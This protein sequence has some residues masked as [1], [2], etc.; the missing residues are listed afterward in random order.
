MDE[1]IIAGIG[2]GSVFSPNHIGNDAAIFSLTAGE[3][4]AMG[5]VV[6]EYP[7]AALAEGGI[8][9]RFIFTMARDKHSVQT[10]LRYENEG[11]TV[12][13]SAYGIRNCTRET[14]TRLLLSHVI[15]HPRSLIV[16]TLTDPLPA[17]RR[18]GF[19]QAWIKRGDIHAIRREDVV[20]IHKPEEAPSVL[21]AFARRGIAR[22]VINEHLQGDLV[23]FYGVAG[24]DFFYWFYPSQVGH[25]KFGLEQVNGPAQGFSFDPRALQRLC[26]RA[27]GILQIQ[28]Y[29]GD[30]V[31][32][33]DGLVRIV[34]FNDWPSFAPCREQAAPFIAQCIYSS[35]HTACLIQ[36][37]V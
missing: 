21:E 24:T 33:E 17:I 14:M 29:G 16:D 12:V 26:N 7:E 1:R 18:A 5:C 22:V 25:S 2:R 31:V 3:L 36:Q 4:R 11:R 6:N 8:D 37:T 28:I 19:R 34:D 15:P 30:C 9:E 13:N 27:A 32:S 23:K 35:I 20:Y 10:L